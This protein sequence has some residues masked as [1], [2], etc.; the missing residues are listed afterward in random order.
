V[1]GGADKPKTIFET[2][3][4][5][6]FCLYPEGVET[7]LPIEISRLKEKRLDRLSRLYSVT[8]LPTGRQVCPG[9]ES[10]TILER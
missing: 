9:G 7:S 3:G 4:V 10:K 2:R 8:S 6:H 1:S 5:N